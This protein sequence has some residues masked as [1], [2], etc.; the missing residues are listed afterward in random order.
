LAGCDCFPRGLRNNGAR[1]SITIF[2]DGLQPAQLGICGC[3]S[4]CASAVH[5]AIAAGNEIVGR[6]YRYGGVMHHL[7]LS[8]RLLWGNLL[9]FTRDRPVKERILRTTFRKYGEH[10]PGNWVTIYATR[11]HV[12][13]VIAGLRFVYGME[14][15][16]RWS[17]LDEP[18]P[19]SR[20]I[21]VRH[22][23]GL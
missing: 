21:R 6:H 15:W 2:R 1:M 4:S 16:R 3:T 5:Q 9:R 13:L 19:S 10:G 11:G 23:S 18:Q 20:R 8:L 22:P 14:K 12:F 17:T 7:G